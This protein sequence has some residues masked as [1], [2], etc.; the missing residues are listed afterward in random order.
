VGA[1]PDFAPPEAAGLLARLLDGG[2][3]MTRKPP[4]DPERATPAGELAPT[5]GAVV[6]ESPQTT[7][8]SV[9]DA[10]GNAVS[11]TTTQS[12][13]FGSKIVIPGT[14]ILLGNAMGAFSETGANAVA[15]GKRMS[16]SMTPT[17]V[18]RDG[19]A[20]LVLGSPG[21]DTIPN[22]VAQVLRN[23]VDGGMT[24]D[25]AVSHARIHHPWLPDRIRIEQL[26]PPAKAALEELSR[27]GHVVGFDPMPIG[28]ANNLLVDAAGVAW[29]CADTRE[30]G[31][32]EGVGAASGEDGRAEKAGER[33]PQVPP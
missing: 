29:G 8:F 1:D 26:N 3:L 21:G 32:A 15:P 9:I 22:T 33:T 11:C 28:D 30:G 27:R 25:E 17:V 4:I 13:S 19:K 12:A 10:Q 31:R 18:S 2:R 5:H 6:A 7:H 24:I 16:S 23:A 14:G 20:A